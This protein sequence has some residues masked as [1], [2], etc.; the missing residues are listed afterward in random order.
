MLR[1][2]ACL[3][4]SA[5]LPLHTHTGP[6]GTVKTLLAIA[7]ADGVPFFFTSGFQFNEVDV[8]LGAKRIASFLRRPR[9]IFQ[10][11]Y[12]SSTYPLSR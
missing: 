2:A 7:G 5:H 9:K 12:L 11:S 6:P 4:T 10:P 1:N 3:S 8:E